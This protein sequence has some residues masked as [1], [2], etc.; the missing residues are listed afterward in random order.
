MGSLSGVRTLLGKQAREGRL[1]G[2]KESKRGRSG[3]RTLV[4]VALTLG[5]SCGAPTEED[6]SEDLRGQELERLAEETE[7]QQEEQM[8]AQEQE[9]ADRLAGE[10]EEASPPMTSESDA[11]RAAACA[12]WEKAFTQFSSFEAGNEGARRALL[13]ALSALRDAE[14]PTE[15]QPDSSEL[16]SLDYFF[17]PLMEYV[18]FR[19]GSRDHFLVAA[20]A[21][22]ASC[23]P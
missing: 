16:E 4:M 19:K 8:E 14:L 7:V 10:G 15:L 20:G 6:A 3:V 13:D 2:A 22:G 21:L 12:L 5:V 23:S 11:A 9:H 17:D 18:A 1:A